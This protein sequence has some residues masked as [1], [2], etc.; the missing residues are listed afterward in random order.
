MRRLTLAIAATA[1][2]VAATPASADTV[3]DWGEVAG[4]YGLA[5]QAGLA[6]RMPG[7]ERATART[8]LAMFEAVNAIDR[9]YQSYL[10]VPQG[11]PAASQDSAAATAAFRVL[12]AHYPANLTNLEES[13]AMTMAAIP[14]GPAKESGRLI[15]ERAAEMAVSTRG[16]DPSIPQEAYRPRTSAG[17]W[18][19]ASLP[20]LESYWGA[21]TPWV[22]TGR[23]ELAI[24]PPPP[25]GSERY[26]RDYEEVRRLGGRTSTERT[27]AQTLIGR[28]REGYS[29]TPMVRYV[30]DRP[31]RSQVDNARLLALYQMAADDAIQA[32]IVA[33]L[34]YN[35]WRPITAIR[36]GA[37]DGN[38]ST[39]HDPAWVPLLGTPNFQEYPCGHCTGVAVQAEVL[40]LIGGLPESTPV[41]VASGS[42]PNLVLQTVASW[43]EVVRQV[44]DSRIFGGVHYRFSNEAGEDIGRRAARLAVERALRPLPRRRRN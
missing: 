29:L 42:N 31:G 20:T 6:P 30:T 38:D 12:L 3:T 24:P 18:I 39:A 10:A 15:G 9:R 21:F 32:M 41:R 5:V 34:R 26:A 2:A 14:D 13:Y 27:P 16:L 36:N 4:R 23:D 37:S 40:R 1:A 28:Y 17:E 33:K 11:D 8:A 19:G 35:Y 44:S 43:D 25:L 22:A 7:V